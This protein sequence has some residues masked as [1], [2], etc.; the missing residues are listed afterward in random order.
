MLLEGD[1]AKL[2]D[3]YCEAGMTHLIL[4][5]DAPDYDLGQLE[6]MCAWRDRVM[7]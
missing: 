1:E 5:L 7:A 3:S 6:Q 4:T 2:A